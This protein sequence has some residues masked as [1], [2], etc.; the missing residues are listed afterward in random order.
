MIGCSSIPFCV[1]AL[2]LSRENAQWAL[3]FPILVMIYQEKP[4]FPSSMAHDAFLP[5][6]EGTEGLSRV[7]AGMQLSP[8]E[9]EDEMPELC[10]PLT[11]EVMEDPVICS[12]KVQCLPV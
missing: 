9:V 3:D 11:L 8:G 5:M 2:G 4:A 10:C 6:Q 12:G 7:F 1:L